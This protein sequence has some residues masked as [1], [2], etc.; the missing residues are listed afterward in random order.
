MHR[1]QQDADEIEPV[2]Q[3][4]LERRHE[5]PVGVVLD[6]GCDREVDD[7]IDEER[8]DDDAGERHRASDDARAR[9]AIHRV[10]YRACCSVLRDERDGE[11]DVKEQQP[12]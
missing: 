4:L 3:R 11:H 9:R 12:E 8:E 7:V 10:A 1:Q 2:V 6:R 5:Q